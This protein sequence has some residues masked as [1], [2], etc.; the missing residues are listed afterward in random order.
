MI[1]EGEV[2][3]RAATGAFLIVSEDILTFAHVNSKCLFTCA[4]RLTP[5]CEEVDVCLWKCECESDTGKFATYA[6]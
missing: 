4:N 3:L 2:P 5:I 6:P 1:E